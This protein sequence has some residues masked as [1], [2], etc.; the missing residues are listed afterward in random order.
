MT[1]QERACPA[2]R[3]RRTLRLWGGRSLCANCKC[4]WPARQI[5]GECASIPDPFTSGEL[6]RLRN[7]RAAIAS[8]LYTDSLSSAPVRPAASGTNTQVIW[9]RRSHPCPTC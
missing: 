2:C 5:P 8:G 4:Q 3:I 1:V 9:S 7:Y 6:A